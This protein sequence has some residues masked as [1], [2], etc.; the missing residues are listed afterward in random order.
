MNTQKPLAVLALIVCTLATSIA[1][2]SLVDRG[3]G[4]I[5]DDVLNVT[6]LQDANYAQTSGYSATGK[7]D[8]NSAQDWAANLVYHDSVR[9]VDYSDWRLAYNTPV[10]GINFNYSITFNG[11]TDVGYNITSPMSELAYMY[12]VNLGLIGK[13]STTGFIQDDFGIFSNGTFN[14]VNQ[15]SFGQNNVGLVTNLQ[16]N[17]YWS[18][19]ED[20]QH[21]DWAWIFRTIW[22]DQSYATK[23]S[24]CCYA[25]AVRPGDVS[26]IPVPGAIWLFCGALLGLLVVNRRKTV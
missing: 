22:G 18:G 12:Y 4:L 20:A 23:A 26:A 1:Q 24:P 13:Y 15:S 5:Y 16:A 6:W 2:A 21:P 10:N 14:G 11:S 9:N 7:L 19:I 3:G 25:W 8:W 17:V